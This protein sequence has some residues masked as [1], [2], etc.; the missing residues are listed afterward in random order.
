[1]LQTSKTKNRGSTLQLFIKGGAYI[2]K[3]C[4]RKGPRI[5]REDRIAK[6]MKQMH[7]VKEEGLQNRA[8]TAKRQN[9]K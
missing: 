3:K 7:A 4:C 5:K 2:M 1:M 9:K 8:R 6:K